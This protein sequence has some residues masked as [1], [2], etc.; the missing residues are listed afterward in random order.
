MSSSKSVS[1][2]KDSDTSHRRSDS[3]SL[4]SDYGSSQGATSRGSN[5]RTYTSSNQLDPSRSTLQEA[6]HSA[7]H[8][9]DE[10]KAKA[11]DAEA[12]LKEMRKKYKEL[13][14]SWSATT[15]RN[16]LLVSE[17]KELARQKKG[18]LDENMTLH[19]ENGQLRK[20]LEG[21]EKKTKRLSEA[22]TPRSPTK[23]HPDASSGKVRLSHSRAPRDRQ[24][25]DDEP[26]EKAKARLAKRFG[27]SEASSDS[28]ADDR[29]EG[30]GKSERRNR[31][32]SYV[33]PMGPPAA[34]P[35][36]SMPPSPIRH[37][38]HEG[39]T[40]TSPYPV[41][42]TPT[43]EPLMSPV[44]RSIPQPYQQPLMSPYGAANES[45]GY[46]PYPLPSHSV[47]RG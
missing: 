20:D 14:A 1:F 6:L 15:E 33:E 35:G 17:N 39:Y 42:Y 29:S 24:I 44:P 37:R 46:F 7:L 36:V 21:L 11:H 40:A 26:A 19:V 5:E 41:P 30:S 2:H 23:E 3:G 32:Q 4:S 8:E 13:E 45:G 9:R 28:R 16:K 34:R 18:V 47:R 31:R 10:W 12:E 38:N 27:G 43:H 25:T 22:P